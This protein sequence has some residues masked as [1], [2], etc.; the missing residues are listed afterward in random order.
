[1]NAQN[2][3][4]YENVKLVKT[5]YRKLENFLYLLGISPLNTAKDWEGS[6]YWEY[7]DTPQLRFAVEGFRNLEEGLKKMNEH[8]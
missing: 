3:K 5:Y 4:K 8:L 7:E 6:T 2:K 1:M